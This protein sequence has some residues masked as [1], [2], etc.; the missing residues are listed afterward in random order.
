MFVFVIS[1]LTPLSWLLG[2]NQLYHC[3]QL[4]HRE[5]IS[6]TFMGC[7][8]IATLGWGVYTLPPWAR[9]VLCYWH[10]YQLRCIVETYPLNTM[11]DDDE[12]TPKPAP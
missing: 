3:Y 1:M 5:E 12:Y 7:F 9:L 2:L 8:T 4:Y 10:V 11:E 6:H